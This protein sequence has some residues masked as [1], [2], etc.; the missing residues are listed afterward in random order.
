MTKT[1]RIF[2][3]SSHFVWG[4]SS[5]RVNEGQGGRS[6]TKA[7]RAFDESSD[8]DNF[9]SPDANLSRYQ[10]LSRLTCLI[11]LLL[12]WK[13][14]TVFF[15]PD[16]DERVQSLVVRT[17]TTPFFC[18]RRNSAT[19][20]KGNMITPSLSEWVCQVSLFSFFN[21]DG[22]C[23]VCWNLKVR[24]LCLCPADNTD[25]KKCG[26]AQI[27]ECIVKAVSAPVL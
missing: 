2:G 19:L 5:F 15:W 16:S 24:V 17:K 18:V 7:Q 25:K 3:K 8:A 27:L 4:F 22:Q 21:L 20:L 9:L 14:K 1:L 23:S 10:D 11:K 6:C 26:T 13:C 12:S